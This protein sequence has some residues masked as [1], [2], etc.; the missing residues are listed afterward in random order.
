MRPTDLLL[1]AA[2]VLTS[3]NLTAYAQQHQHAPSLEAHQHGVATLNIALEEQQLALELHSPAINIVGFEYQP[4]SDADKQ[5]VLV[6]ERTL[7]NEQLLFKLTPAAQCAL[8]AVSINNDL[9]EHSDEHHSPAEHEDQHQHSDIQV[10]YQFNCAVPAKLAEI[11]LDGVFKAF[12]LTET[13]HVQLISANAQQGV[14]LSQGNTAI[15]W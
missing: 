8:S 4:R 15:R 7:K 9:A 10:S 2:L 14:E 6:A 5:A 1:P 12:P 3:F 13:I 11:D